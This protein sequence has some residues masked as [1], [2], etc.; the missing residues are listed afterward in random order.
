MEDIFHEMPGLEYHKKF[1]R[2]LQNQ[3]FAQILIFLWSEG[4]SK[5]DRREKKIFNL[6]FDG[7]LEVINRRDVRFSENQI[8]LLTRIKKV[9]ILFELEV[10]TGL[11]NAEGLK[12]RIRD[13]VRAEKPLSELIEEP[14]IA[15]IKTQ[16]KELRFFTEDMVKTYLE[17]LE[18]MNKDEAEKV[19]SRQLEYYSRLKTGDFLD[20]FILKA[21]SN[22]QHS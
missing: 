14:M 11:S 18:E 3:E 2:A 17:I 12:K 21:M 6:I 8:K 13:H 4:I 9:L 16:N 5:L 19:H 15:K 7:Y 1:T 22:Y 20:Q 10:D